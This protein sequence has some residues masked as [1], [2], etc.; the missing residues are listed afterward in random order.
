V[1]DDI[2]KRLDEIEKDIVHLY[3]QHG[4]KWPR[5]P[6]RLSA[7]EDACEVVNGHIVVKNREKGTNHGR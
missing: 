6:Q 4:L 1:T 3:S 7:G 5:R 2:K